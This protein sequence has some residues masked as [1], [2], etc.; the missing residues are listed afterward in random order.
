VLA[1]TTLLAAA[2]ACGRPEGKCVPRAAAGNGGLSLGILRDVSYH[3][4]VFDNGRMNLEMEDG[5][6]LVFSAPEQSGR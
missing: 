6:K 5:R 1:A 2:V 3:P 4:A